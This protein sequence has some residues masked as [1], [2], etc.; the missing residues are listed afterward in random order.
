MWLLVI[1]TSLWVFFDAKRIGIKKGQITG[2]ANLGPG[3]WLVVCLFLWIIAF[4][5]YL[6]KRP[7]FIRI[8]Q[9]DLRSCWNKI[10]T[11]VA[12]LVGILVV[13]FIGIKVQEFQRTPVAHQI[14]DE[15]I[16]ELKN[17]G[18]DNLVSLIGKGYIQETIVRNG[19]SYYLG[20]L[21]S[22]PDTIKGMHT[23]ESKEVV[24]ALRPG[25]VVNEVEVLGYVDC[26]TIIPFVYFKMGPSFGVVINKNGGVTIPKQ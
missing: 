7:Q 5:T 10:D 21:V 9:K 11:A 20:Y 2:I 6:I 13:W 16:Q 12:V 3:G 19:V 18:F 25:E 26:I 1:V 4:P 14:I 15:R 17:K 24:S 23:N 8:N 22:K